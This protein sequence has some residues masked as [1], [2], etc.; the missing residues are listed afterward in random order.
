[1]SLFYKYS[2]KN[3]LE[4]ISKNLVL[5]NCI[6]A[7]I[8]LPLKKLTREAGFMFLDVMTTARHAASVL[9]NVCHNI[10]LK[11]T[12]TDYIL[13]FVALKS[14]KILNFYFFIFACM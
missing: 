3:W 13:V 2:S 12:N 9:V 6:D 14:I 1:V 8:C 7:Q 10:F 5:P 4:I 11:P